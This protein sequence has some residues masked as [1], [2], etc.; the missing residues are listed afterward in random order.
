[1]SPLYLACRY[2]KALK[3]Q[4]KSLSCVR[5][6]ITGGADVNA[7]AFGASTPLSE[8]AFS[9]WT[10][11]FALLISNGAHVS[12]K[13]LGPEAAKMIEKAIDYSSKKDHFLAMANSA[14]AKNAIDDMM[15]NLNHS[16]ARSG[17]KFQ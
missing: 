2:S 10:D 17:I 1:M 13:S 11:V 3:S 12:E 15:N 5:V 4:E 16:S 7:I 8:S 14:R 9:G 6:L